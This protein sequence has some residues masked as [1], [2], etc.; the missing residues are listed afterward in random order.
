MEFT[1]GFNCFSITFGKLVGPP[2]TVFKP[3]TYVE[4][5]LAKGRRTADD[6]NNKSRGHSEQD[7]MYI[8]T[9]MAA[10]MIV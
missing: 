4:S 9:N 1:L 2:L 5:W 7:S 10:V 8:P 6:T 3:S